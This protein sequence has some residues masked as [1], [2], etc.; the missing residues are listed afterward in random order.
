MLPR[1]EDHPHARAVLT[2]ALPPGQASHAYLF[3]GPAGAGKREVARA[4]AAALLADGA[5]DPEAAAE[6]VQRGVHPDL[7]W[8]SPSGAAEMLV[9]DVDQAVVAAAALTPFEARRR[10]WVLERAE[11]MNDQAANRLLKTLE[12]PPAFAHLILIADRPEDL[13]ATIASRCQRVRFDPPPPARIAERLL[14][15]GVAPEHAEAAAR[16]SLGDAHRARA[17]AAEPGRELR[18]SAEGLVREGHCQPLLDQARAAGARARESEQ[19]RAAAELELL[20][21]RERRRAERE[22][23]ER[24]QRAE[25]RARTAALDEGLRLAGLWLRDAACLAMGAGEVIH[26]VDRREQ[27]ERDIAGRDPAALRRGLELVEDTRRRLPVFVGEDL[28]LD[29]LALRLRR[30][31][32]A[33]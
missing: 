1:L 3:A 29:A 11:T 13:L 26:A 18:A 23:A 2:P 14:A 7:V 21:S 8:V 6:R 20:P 27:L 28:A 31:L 4:F 10:V 17:L 19:E 32:S 5:D 9:A 33:T 24:A 16:L 25:R 15:E 30:E 12:E 22:A